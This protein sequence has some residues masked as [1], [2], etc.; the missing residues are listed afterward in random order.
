M[1]VAHL[2][3]LSPFTLT[4]RK[5]ADPSLVGAAWPL[6]GHSSQPADQPANCSQTANQLIR[7]H[8][9][10]RNKTIVF[11]ND[12]LQFSQSVRCFSI[13]CSDKSKQKNSVASSFADLTKLPEKQTY[14]TFQLAEIPI[15]NLDQISP[16]SKFPYLF[17]TDICSPVRT[18]LAATDPVLL[19][20]KIFATGAGCALAFTVVLLMGLELREPL[21]YGSLAASDSV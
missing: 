9:S 11:K 10:Q 6:L 16:A 1:S 15:D 19:F 18:Q 14:Y 17:F 21:I 8:Q 20:E 12:G 7:Q 13:F 5:S 3:H 2:I 4:F